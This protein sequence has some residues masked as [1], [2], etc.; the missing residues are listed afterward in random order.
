MHYLIL[1]EID[2]LLNW[3]LDCTFRLL[4]HYLL[5]QELYFIDLLW[6]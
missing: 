2:D 4:N 6:L 5:A 3:G 1:I